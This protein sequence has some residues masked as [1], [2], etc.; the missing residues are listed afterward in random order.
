MYDVIT[1][2][3]LYYSVTSYIPLVSLMMMMMVHFSQKMKPLNIDQTE[4]KQ[5]DIMPNLLSLHV[6][7]G[8]DIDSK[9]RDI[10]K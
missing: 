2:M 3:Y 1:K 8:C 5:S 10:G 4:L 7:S 9:I 6:I